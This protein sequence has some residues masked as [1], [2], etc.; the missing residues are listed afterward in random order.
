M[1]E[2]WLPLFPVIV[3]KM[4]GKHPAPKKGRTGLLRRGPFRWLLIGI[5]IAS[6][7]FYFPKVALSP[8]TLIPCEVEDPGCLTGDTNLLTTVLARAGARL[9]EGIPITLDDRVF[10]PYPNAWA[11]GEPCLLPAFAGFPWAATFRSYALGYNVPHFLAC[12]LTTLAAG[13]LF[14]QLAGKGW[15]ALLAALVFSWGPARMNNFGV[16]TILWAGMLPFV[17]LFAI[18]FLKWGRPRDLLFTFFAWLA[19]G[20]GSLY[21]LAMGSLVAAFVLGALG[22]SSAT[23]R[24][25]LPM[26]ALA[27]A[28]AA[29]LMGLLFRPYFR[30]GS[31]LGVT[32]TRAMMEGQSADILS[33]LHTGAFSGPTRMLLDRFGPHFP[34]GTSALF[35][36]FFVFLAMVLFVAARITKPARTGALRLERHPAFWFAIAMLVFSFALGPTIR[37]GGKPLGP[38][39]WTLV[40]PLPVFG[41]IRGLFRWDQW[42]GFA[43]A[44]GA[45]LVLSRAARALTPARGGLLLAGASFL[46]LFDIWPRPVPAAALPP[47]SPFTSLYRAL[48]RN[49]VVAVFPYTRESS[50][51]SWN[52]QLHHGRRVLNGFQTFPPPIH[53][54]LFRR[55]RGATPD[56]A[57]AYLRE[58][59]ADAVEMDGDALDQSS[60]D[61]LARLRRAPPAFVREFRTDGDRT[62]FFLEHRDP[63]LVDSTFLKDLEFHGGRT[64]LVGNGPGRLLFRVGPEQRRVTLRHDSRSWEE[65]L[66][67]P[68]VGIAGLPA[69]LSKAAPAGTTVVDAKTGVPIG[70]VID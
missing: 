70:S 42:Y 64:A 39:P 49:A 14:A 22:L 13:T 58:L 56:E 9:R 23:R 4:G 63:L 12:I 31:D 15:A 61:L 51:R 62:A 47:P 38:G 6:P 48:P 68:V 50:Q 1:D 40:S 55:L 32:V 11:T 20:L 66:T 3:S 27:S 43:L 33:I 60:R 59:G 65:T 16:L 2:G 24:R 26:V 52:E 41:A 44:A 28:G 54:W 35:P 8:L 10:A 37:Y 69:A 17:L 45:A 67:L 29:L 5:S 21:G 34:N 53:A 46:A 25:R 30:A 19:L 7:L 57:L 18:R 36:T